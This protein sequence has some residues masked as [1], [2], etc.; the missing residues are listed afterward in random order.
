MTISHLSVQSVQ[1]QVS[2]EHF[3]SFTIMQY[4]KT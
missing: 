2:I 1:L 3:V 4:Y